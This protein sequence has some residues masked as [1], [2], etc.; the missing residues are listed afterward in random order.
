MKD[1]VLG[2]VIVILM[3]IAG[4]VEQ[5]G[6][7]PSPGDI[8]VPIG[9]ATGPY[10]GFSNGDA[11]ID[12]QDPVDASSGSASLNVEVSDE[13]VWGDGYYLSKSSCSD[14]KD[15]LTCQWKKFNY[16]GTKYPGSNWIESV[17]MSGLKINSKEFFNGKNVI[18]AY[19]CRSTGSGFDCNNNQWLIKEFTVNFQNATPPAHRVLQ[20]GGVIDEKET[21]IIETLSG[22]RQ[23]KVSIG[24]LVGVST[25]GQFALTY[26]LSN[27]Y[28][29]VIMQYFGLVEPSGAPSNN[30]LLAGDGHGA[31]IEIM[32]GD[33]SDD[34]V[35][36]YVRQ[37]LQ[38][39]TTF[40]CNFAEYYQNGVVRELDID[41]DGNV[42]HTISLSGG[43]WQNDAPNF[44]ID[45]EPTGFITLNTEY[46]TNSSVKIK[47]FIIH[48]M[49][50]LFQGRRVVGACVDFI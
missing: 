47:P 6:L 13:F 42:D 44:N 8:G 23:Y 22:V 43:D 34:K 14:P 41:G 1:I 29:D 36:L 17:G 15:W 2:I 45:G 46:T 38:P 31:I 18:L 39:P 19:S 3:F 4:C 20:N 16:N 49:S 12:L 37:S 35:E 9:K 32:P 26:E 30:V 28:D 25:P 21:V 11:I 40:G 27:E 50:N 10:P 24:P 5:S 33:T 48:D 7:P